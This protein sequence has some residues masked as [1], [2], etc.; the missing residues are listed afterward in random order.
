M[1]RTVSSDMI[2]MMTAE[3]ADDALVLLISIDHPDMPSPLMVTSEVEETVSN[4]NTY[5][6]YPFYFTIPDEPERG[7]SS[8]ASIQ[9]ANVD[10]KIVETLR[11]IGGAPQFD[12]RLVRRSAPD[13]VENRWPAFKLRTAPYDALFVS[14]ELVLDDYYLMPFPADN[15]LPIWFPGLF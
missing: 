12:A 13:E 8:R 4:G 11:S 5:I 14:G 7:Q 2:R 15:Y 6:P 10:R 9:I 3:Y 1:P